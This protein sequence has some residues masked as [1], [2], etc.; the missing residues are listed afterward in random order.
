MQIMT[1]FTA[2]DQ[3]TPADDIT[4]LMGTLN[5][6]T[7]LR[8]DDDTKNRDDSVPSTPSTISDESDPQV[9]RFKLDQ[10]IQ[11]MV[12]AFA[13]VHQHDHRKDY[14]E[15][16]KEWSESNADVISREEVR[17]VGLGYNGNVL[18][19]MY[20]AGRYYFR[21]KKV[22]TNKKAKKRRQYISMDNGI[23]TAMDEHITLNCSNENYT[24]AGG[25]SDFVEKNQNRLFNEIQRL[26][27]EH[28]NSLNA[29]DIQLKVKKTYKNRYYLYTRQQN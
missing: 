22:E 29:K 24:P 19:K 13:K 26:M 16:W 20:K 11:E 4:K 8:R 3:A 21:T 23:L 5:I 9:F 1:T 28:T 6:N 17:L 27:Q 14:K 18:D 2:H 25:Y 15:A 7:G 12:T 10:T